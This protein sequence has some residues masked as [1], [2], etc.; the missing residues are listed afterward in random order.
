MIEASENR[1][2]KTRI[3]SA[4]LHAEKALAHRV[5]KLIQAD[6]HQK[7]KKSNLYLIDRQGGLNLCL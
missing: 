7:T 6:S 5:Q 3:L 1:G 4:F 2:R